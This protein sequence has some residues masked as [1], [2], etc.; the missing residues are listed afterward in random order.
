MST[1][2]IRNRSVI[3]AGGGPAGA[4]TALLLARE[5]AHVTVLERDAP[6]ASLGA[7]LLLQPNGLAVLYALGLRDALE[8]AATR[9]T[10][11]T[12]RNARGRVLVHSQ[13]PDYG[14]GL[15]HVLALRRSHLASVLGSALSEAP[16]VEAHFEAEVVDAEPSGSLTYTSTGAEHQVAADVVIGADGVHSS[17]RGHGGFGARLHATGHTYVR[18]IVSGT[19]DVEPGEYWTA[20]GLFGCAPLGDGTTY[21]YGDA[22]APSIERSLAA[23]DVSS[24]QNAWTAALP[25][26]S[27]LIRAIAS[28]ADLLVNDVYRVDCASFV[29]RRLVILGDAAH[30]MA[31]T[32]GQGANS[33]F[34]DGA[35][36]VDELRRHDSI[37]EAL[38]AYDLRRR[39][40]VQR[41]QRDADRVAR[42]SATTS[43]VGRA[44]RDRALS[45][46]N[47]PRSTTR[48]YNKSL[49]HDPSDLMRMVGAPPATRARA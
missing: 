7:G 14:N 3:I 11:V 41:V 43:A 12:V 45:A 47:R 42:L 36:L 35:V 39:P 46:L 18:G 22:T 15:D 20:L 16:G 49:Q 23:A 6:S 1:S 17:V 38:A 8:V 4:V 30:A 40:T 28:T 37:E 27:P 24:L 44:I 25:A 10:A 2:V 32:L 13:V 34:V 9:S 26:M 31:P 5:G 19:F 48:R 33:A 21:F 29:D